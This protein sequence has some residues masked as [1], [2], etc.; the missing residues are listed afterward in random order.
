MSIAAFAV[1]RPVATI[2][3]ILAVVLL[4][5]VS[6]SRLPVSLLPD[7]SL[8]VLTI[9]T[10][11]TGAAAPE[12]SRFVAEPI[13]EAIAA[14]PGLVELRSVSRNGEVTTTARF[15]WGTD[16]RGTVLTVR[17][18]LDAARGQLP[19]R[20]DRPTLLT[21]DPGERPIAVLAI[22]SDPNKGGGDL[23]S[24]ARTASDVHARRLEQIEGVAS[25]AVVGAPEDQIRVDLD[26]DRLRALN[27]TPEDV[28]AAIRAQNSTGAGGTIRK[29]Q[30]RFSVRALTE[31]RTPSEILD[32]PVGPVGAGITLRDVGTVTLALADPETL[33]RLDGAPAI[34]LVVYKDAGSNTVAVT[35]RMR[36]AIDVLQK[37][38]VGTNINIVAAQ[39]DFVVDALSNLGQEI[40]AGGLLSLLVIL[41]F[42]RDWRVSLAIGLVVPL[43]VLVALVGLQAL[44]VSI[45]VLSL[46]G[47]ALGTGLLVDTAIVVAES[48]GRR[49]EEGM[50]LLE[51]A[52]VGTDEVAAPLFAGTLTTVLVFGPIIFVRGL[53]AALF[54]DLSLSVV[55]TVAASLALSLTLMPVMIIGRRRGAAARD[56]AMQK[57]LAGAAHATNATHANGS[58]THGAAS[59]A[60]T[61]AF[62]ATLDRWGASLSALYER[63]MLWSL[64]HV[65][66]VF[67]LA[68]AAVAVTGYLIYTLPKE[69][70]PRV[71]EGVL[72]A[73]LQL[74]EGTSIEATAD[75]VAR[76][77]KAGRTLGATGIYARV[78]KATDEEIL[79]G[80][81]PGSSATA[82]II[83][84]VPSRADAADF[85]Q[86][87][88]KALP[89]LA[90]GALALDL[91]GQSEFGSLIGREGRLVRVELS[92]AS[93]AQTQ[94][95]ADTV[96]RA[97][98]DISSLSDVRDAFAESQPIVE[99]TL[100]R[101]RMA[102]RGIVP[103]QVASALAG[104][105]GGVRASDL[106]ETDKR[107]PIAVRYT[108]Q[109]NEQLETALQTPIRG[110]P[111]GQLVD[112]RETRAPLEVIRIGQR[113]VT[114]IEGLVETGGTAK[115]T[116]DVT[117]RMQRIA[118]PSGVTW[119][120]AGADAERKRTSDELTL[121]VILAALLMFLVL[122]GEFASFTIPLVVML[123]VPLAGAGAVIF[124]WMTGQSLNA[125]SLIGIV[126]MIGMADNEAV[127][128]LD[129]IRKFR[130]AGHSI[131]E[132]I[133]L[134]G[135]QRLRAIAMTSI[136]TVTGVLPL[137]F[138]WGSGGALYQ[139]LA[140]G[141]IGGSVSALLVTFFLLPT[142]Y[143]VLERR[144]ERRAAR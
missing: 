101:E 1:R 43:S 6:L 92:A 132:A 30:F 141:I 59:G 38:F 133:V 66:T 137:V 49:R 28:A 62:G 34:G 80:A 113:P 131:D 75:Q 90:N 99:V 109:R 50:P 58:G 3:A 2:A 35:S 55:T 64:T 65:G 143:A 144:L 106:R 115:A 52:I 24:L 136:T 70:L 40:V 29:G 81:D 89:D 61:S 26:P 142:A 94:Q 15:A 31:F 72:V 27:L 11:Y 127:V 116:D 13:E 114:V 14:T 91:A 117:G 95:W 110:I 8:P 78:G 135:Q 54:R 98:R 37:E 25:V 68:I 7:V 102:E 139:P 45:N 122:A 84:P 10:V 123:T 74:P 16:M 126:V 125:V 44:G 5:S 48:V 39:A 57:R 86:Q 76:V 112:I 42:L 9:R 119:Q 124:L 22:K 140:A 4:G 79:G 63:G 20:A 73:Q 100:K 69:I 105:L 60:Q 107:T 67:A 18:H 41:L 46:G 51:A 103:E 120:V 85:A 118:L 87:L 134:G 33:T 23:R 83:V 121:V 17:E 128:K 53:A 129:A 82:Q 130:E 108:G 138:G 19:D 71:D 12:V 47:L 77:E 111:L 21:S 97:M 88:R 93:I 32:T 36:E 96:R 56:A 104:A